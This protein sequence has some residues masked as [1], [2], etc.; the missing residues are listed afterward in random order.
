M[1]AD[2]AN[3]I[4]EVKQQVKV[5]VNLKDMCRSVRSMKTLDFA[6]EV[7]NKSTIC[8]FLKADDFAAAS[9]LIEDSNTLCD[10]MQFI[11]RKLLDAPC[12]IILVSI[13]RVCII[14]QPCNVLSMSPDYNT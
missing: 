13:P 5:I 9:M 14:L 4:D 6:T 11:A 3:R 1:L 2:A 8:N 10:I 7:A 12:Q